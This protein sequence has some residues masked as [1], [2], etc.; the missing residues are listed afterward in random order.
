[1]G[2][3]VWLPSSG[4]VPK[5]SPFVGV[6][7]RPHGNTDHFRNDTVCSVTYLARARPVPT[8]IVLAREGCV[9]GCH[10]KSS[11]VV[12]RDWTPCL[13]VCPVL[14]VCVSCRV[15]IRVPH[16]ARSVFLCGSQ[17]RSRLSRHYISVTDVH[18]T[19]RGGSGIR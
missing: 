17:D 19:T 10:G 11:S 13:Q 14:F 4:S 3:G 2:E 6:P 9:W 5:C 16:Q 8:P 12:G 7:Y 18:N 1:M 15:F